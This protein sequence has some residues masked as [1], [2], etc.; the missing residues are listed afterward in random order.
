[1]ACSGYSTALPRQDT[2]GPAGK[3]GL[4]VVV[5]PPSPFL[6]RSW[7]FLEASQCDWRQLEARAS[8]RLEA[9]LWCQPLLPN[10]LTGGEPYS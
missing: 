3:P 2:A 6:R 7:S 10:A 9:G 8:H 1:M 5:T 4:V